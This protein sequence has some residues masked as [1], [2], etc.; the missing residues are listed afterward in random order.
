M[1]HGGAS[2]AI[3]LSKV[4]IAVNGLAISVS[5][6]I[7]LLLAHPKGCNEPGW[8]YRRNELAKGSA[9]VAKRAVDSGMSESLRAFYTTRIRR[10][11]SPRSSAGRPEGSCNAVASPK[12]ETTRPAWLRSILSRADPSS[13]AIAERES[14]RTW[15]R[16]REGADPR[17]HPTGIFAISIEGTLSRWL[18]RLGTPYAVPGFDR[19]AAKSRFPSTLTGLTLNRRLMA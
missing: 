8:V 13:G 12:K 9:K 15:E 19:S 17:I 16:Q 10:A 6:A 2:A 11:G 18:N 4:G 3:V 14:G 5:R 1:C 7:A